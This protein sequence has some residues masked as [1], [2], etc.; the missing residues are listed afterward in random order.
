M[1]K[2][3]ECTRFQGYSSNAPSGNRPSLRHR[4][5]FE[6]RSASERSMQSC[7]LYPLVLRSWF[8]PP[9]YE[10]TWAHSFQ[11]QPKAS[12]SFRL[13]ARHSPWPWRTWFRPP[14]GEAYTAYLQNYKPMKHY[15]NRLELA[16]VLSNRC[17]CIS[18]RQGAKA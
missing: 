7:I 16:N 4:I 12:M 15:R 2:P 18:V 3:P 17:P 1:I 13:P 10:P 8:R 5:A 9:R 14:R 11:L 6:A